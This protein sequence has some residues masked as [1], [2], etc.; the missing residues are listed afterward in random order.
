VAKR[1]QHKLKPH[2]FEGA[3]T[4][5]V[6]LKVMSTTITSCA[7]MAINGRSTSHNTELEAGGGER[8][9]PKCLDIS[10]FLCL[11]FAVKSFE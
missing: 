8:K 1:Q 9:M 10:R 4:G 5:K 3:G 11:A 7:Y 2:Q 6:R